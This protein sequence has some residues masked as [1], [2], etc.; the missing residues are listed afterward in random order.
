MNN[1]K[2]KQE[3]LAELA[4]L[5]QQE[6]KNETDSA[7]ADVVNSEE[8]KE[9]LTKRATTKKPDVVEDAEETTDEATPSIIDGYKILPLVELPHNGR[10]YPHTWSFAY[11]CPTADEIANFSSVNEND[12]PSIINAIQELIRKC[13]VIIDTETQRQVS[14]LEI[15]DGDRVFFLLKLREFYL[16][17]Q[18]ISYNTMCMSCKEEI[19]VNLTAA[20]LQ[21][22]P[23]SD[24][25]FESFDG[26]T[27]SL[28]MGLSSGN[29][30]F[31]I[32]TFD[33]SQRIFRYIMNTY[34]NRDNSNKESEV[35]KKEFLLVAPFLYETGKE[36]IGAL[37][38]KFRQISRDGER[39]KAYVDLAN[40]L[41]FDN[42]E[43]FIYTHDCG[44]EEV[45]EI[46]FPG[47]WK[48]LFIGK[49]SYNGL[50]E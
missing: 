46:R 4:A 34:K 13:V 24:K 8:H 36:S 50:F 43:T 26:R 31:R 38:N 10:L 12:Q 40:N 30:V 21:Y 27:F 41:K 3:K 23:I 25:I 49:N 39:L 5:E 16:G 37:K 32:P 11:R 33:I 9:R 19:I 20:S 42:K 6:R 48:K 28:D 44:S 1:S 14:S 18:P 22:W 47:G 45:A 29:V 17:N 15:N 35:F 2:S 7:I